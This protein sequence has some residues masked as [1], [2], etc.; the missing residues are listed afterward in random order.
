MYIGVMGE[1]R[2]L[3]STM[4]EIVFLTASIASEHAT[5]PI[6]KYM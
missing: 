1:R 6:A 5:C 2:T 4:W 3:S